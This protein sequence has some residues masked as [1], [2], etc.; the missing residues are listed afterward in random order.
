MSELLIE[1]I[2]LLKE[3]SP[4]AWAVLVKQVYSNATVSFFWGTVSLVYIFFLIQ[5]L[6]GVIKSKDDL[7]VDEETHIKIVVVGALTGCVA[8]LVA[9]ACFVNFAQ[10]TF[11]PEYYAIQLIIDGL[12]K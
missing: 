2:A 7:E 5:F 6:R 4:Q 11:N 3:A 1:L 9:V 12:Q 10:M 8:I